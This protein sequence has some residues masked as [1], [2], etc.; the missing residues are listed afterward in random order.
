MIPESFMAKELALVTAAAFAGAAIYINVAEQPARLGLDNKALLAQ[1]KPSYA[2]G[3]AMQASLALASALFGLLAFWLTRDWRWMLGA[4]LIFA[5]WPYT[6]IVILPV[7]KRLEATP[8]ESANA[9]SR[10]L[11]E[12]WGKLHAGR[13][14]LGVA[15]TLVYLWAIT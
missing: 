7:N 9:A 12:T 4:L 10:V 5:N 14:A 15:A 2:G 1:W 8:P 11:I 6:L 3:F 13:S